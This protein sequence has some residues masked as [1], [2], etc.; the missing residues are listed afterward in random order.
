M[1]VT[2]DLSGALECYLCQGGYINMA[3]FEK[4][5]DPLGICHHN[6]RTALEAVT[7]H[8]I[9]IDPARTHLNE[10]WTPQRTDEKG[11]ILTKRQYYNK[12]L[13]EVPHLNRK[14]VRT[15]VSWVITLPK[16]IPAGS[17]KDREFFRAS[18]DFLSSKYGSDNIISVNI[19]RDEAQP[20]MHYVFM[21]VDARGRI[22]CK[23]LM[24]KAELSGFH[25]QLQSFMQ[26]RGI[27]CN[28]NSG[29][30]RAQGGNRTIAELKKGDRTHEEKHKITRIKR[31]SEHEHG[32][33]RNR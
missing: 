10:D 6:N 18:M 31:Q 17:A 2:I 32:P 21:P 3:N 22:S 28:V 13:A 23:N 33:N 30:T 7:D 26:S 12:R 1:I 27:D 4:I 11:K 29:I 15:A 9:N 14:N 5:D 20:H 19:H 16:E 25:P 8:K 24:T